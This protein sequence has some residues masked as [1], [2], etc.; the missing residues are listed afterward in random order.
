MLQ[1]EVPVTD[2]GVAAGGAR[3]ACVAAVLAG[4]A[5]RGAYEAGA[6]S[7][8]LP[9][10]GAS[11]PRLYVG[12]SAGAINALGFSAFSHLDPETAGQRVMALWR[13]IGQGDIFRPP[14]PTMLRSTA[15]M[16]ARWGGVRREPVGLLDTAP[17]RR[18]LSR[19]VNWDQL[20]VNVRDGHVAACCV[21]AT[22]KS[23]HQSVGFLESGPS[24]PMPEDDDVRGIRFLRATLAP[25]HVV[26]SSSL[27]AL[28]PAVWIPDAHCGG[29]WYVDGGVRLN[30]P[31][32]PALLLGAD[33]IVVVATSPATAPPVAGDALG[34]PPGVGSGLVDILRAVT[35][36]RMV[37]DLGSLVRHNK[38]ADRPEGAAVNQR[39]GDDGAR[40]GG[41]RTVPYVFA[42]P[43]RA[44]ELG[45]LARKVLRSR[46]LWPPPAPLARLVSRSPDLCELMTHVLFDREFIA[47]S[48]AL[49]QADARA[50]LRADG[51]V[52]WRETA[53]PEPPSVA[54]KVAPCER[55]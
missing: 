41:S 39:V 11:Q 1:G 17:L 52:V 44:G 21:V 43:S 9:A 33:R 28:F 32:K 23:T 14:L 18:T 13:G 10:L 24:F 22:D 7:V 38:R 42:G 29:S 36:D 37:E 35:E 19:V 5:A 53:L 3:P 4:A 12:T 26:A 34:R 54:P 15:R 49:G 46:G 47:G 2:Q 27:P 30:A 20:H 25:E 40:R 6:L 8:I 48:I 16:L 45:E 51:G 31:I 50:Q 55:S